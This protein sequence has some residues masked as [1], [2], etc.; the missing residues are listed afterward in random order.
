MPKKIRVSELSRELGVESSFVIAVLRRNGTKE[1]IAPS[2][3]IDE[4]AAQRIREQ[5][6]A[7]DG[8]P[9]PSN[10]NTIWEFFPEQQSEI[11]LEPDTSARLISLSQEVDF[12]RETGPIE[13]LVAKKLSEYF[14]LQH[15]FHSTGIEGNRLSLRET[16]VVLAE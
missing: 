15:I 8:T 11:D 3:D 12:F 1:W 9:Y 13:P 5:F 2:T 16:E 4:E 6:V 7:K 10:P 14:R